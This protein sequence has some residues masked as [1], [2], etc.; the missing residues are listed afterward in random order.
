MKK[1][2]KVS[3]K[4]AKTPTSYSIS[5]E[6]K[7]LLTQLAAKKNR[8]KANMLETLIIEAAAVEKIS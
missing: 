3:I 8:S 2:K 5:D 4:K 1:E 6:A 7:E